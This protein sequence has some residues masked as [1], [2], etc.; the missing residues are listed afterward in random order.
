MLT[1]TIPMLKSSLFTKIHE[2]SALLPQLTASF[3]MQHV[4]FF[5]DG[6]ATFFVISNFCIQFFCLD[7]DTAK[8][9]TIFSYEGKEEDTACK[10]VDEKK[11]AT[12]KK[13]IPVMYKFAKYCVCANAKCAFLA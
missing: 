2:N 10:F 12:Q 1:I 9:S 11:N 5:F 7:F 8:I 3:R 4:S 6:G 13:I